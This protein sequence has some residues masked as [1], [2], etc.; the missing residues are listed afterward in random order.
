MLTNRKTTQQHDASGKKL[1]TSLASKTATLFAEP[2]YTE[3]VAFLLTS[4]PEA[5]REDVS[6]ML[7]EQAD[8]DM[9]LE[10]KIRRAKVIAKLCQQPKIITFLCDMNNDPDKIEETLSALRK[11]MTDIETQ[12]KSKL[13]EEPSF[14][15]H[16]MTTVG[17]ASLN[18]LFPGVG[19]LCAQVVLWH[20]D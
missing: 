2:T 14:L 8:V 12:L 19:L 7:L 10:E 5:L 4:V 6:N 18:H 1:T 15:S 11:K 9:S 13:Q 17:L 20:E 16:F 3:Q